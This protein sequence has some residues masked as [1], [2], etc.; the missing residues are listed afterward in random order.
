MEMRGEYRI[1]APRQEVWRAL[2]DPDVLRRSIPGCEEI[3]KIT[4]THFTAKVTAKLGPVKTSFIGAVTLSDL[5]P[6]NSYTI[7]GEGKGGAAGFAKGGAAV[8]LEPDGDGTLLTYTVNAAVGGKLAQIGSRLIDATARKMA[9]EFFS[10]FAEIV[11]G[12]AA[13]EAP[14]PEARPRGLRPV[15]W[16]PALIVIVILAL[17]YYAAAG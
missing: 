14:P 16:I 13:V 9:N 15:I 3:E 4:D 10:T 11:G 6:P 1:A 7:S 12:P 17:L 2:N 5:D 8:E